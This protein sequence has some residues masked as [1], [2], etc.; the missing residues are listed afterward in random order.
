MK[1]SQALTVNQL[2]FPR[3]SSKYC[4]GC[5]ETAAQNISAVFNSGFVYGGGQFIMG[6][7]SF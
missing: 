7:T 2:F 6:C 3:R 4:S 1:H 5:Q